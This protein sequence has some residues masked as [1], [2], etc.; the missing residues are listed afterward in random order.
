V[1]GT[2]EWP[3]IGPNDLLVVCGKCV[4]SSGRREGVF[5]VDESP[6]GVVVGRV[7]RRCSH[8]DSPPDFPAVVA[9]YLA[10]WQRLSEREREDPTHVMV[11]E[12]SVDGA[13]WT[14]GRRVDVFRQPDP[15]L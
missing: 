8:T 6:D 14:L 13:S 5:V 7:L 11:T 1:W 4:D 10:A 3:D 15:P 9:G 2:R 12:I